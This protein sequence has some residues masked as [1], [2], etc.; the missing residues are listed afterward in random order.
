[1][2]MDFTGAIGGGNGGK[3]PGL[4]MFGR[5]AELPE[6]QPVPGG[7]Y[8]ARV[9]RGKTH[10]SKAEKDFYL[11][12]YEIE[13]GDHAGRKVT[14]WFNLSDARLLAASERVLGVFGLATPEQLLSPFPEAGKAYRVRLTLR[15]RPATDDYPAS[16]DVQRVELLEVLTTP[17]AKYA[18]PPLASEE[19]EGGTQ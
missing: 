1:M 15:V 3:S 18:L 12:E 8:V 17:A 7:F 2:A 6:S 13:S 11:I 4:S 14:Q 10:T 5:S 9:L 16:N 19:K